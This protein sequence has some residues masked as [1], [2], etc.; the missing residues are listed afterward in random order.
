MVIPYSFRVARQCFCRFRAISAKRRFSRAT[1]WESTWE[2]GRSLLAR[3]FWLD[4]PCGWLAARRNHGRSSWS[5]ANTYHQRFLFLPATPSAAS[6]PTELT[7]RPAISIC[8]RSSNWVWCSSLTF[9]LNGL[10]ACDPAHV[11]A[12][13]RNEPRMSAVCAGEG[14]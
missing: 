13:Q 1:R 5:S 4:L 3:A 14:S 12:R 10:P 7:K 6:S 8:N 11:A 2:S 9:I